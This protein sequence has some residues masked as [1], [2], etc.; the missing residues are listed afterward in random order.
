MG[1]AWHMWANAPG[2]DFFERNWLMLHAGSTWW[3]QIPPLVMGIAGIPAV[4]FLTR[5]FRFQAWICL[6]ST[7][8][9]TM[10]PVCIVFS[11]RYKEY[12]ADFLLACLLLALAERARRHPGRRE[13]F[14][15]SAV[16]VAGFAVSASVLPIVAGSW[17]AVGVLALKERQRLLPLLYPAILTGAGILVIGDVFYR[18]L[19]PYLDKYWSS[20][21][22]A[23]NSPQAFVSK[24][25]RLTVNVYAGLTGAPRGSQLWILVSFLLLTGLLVLGLARGWSMLSPL[26]MLGSAYVACALGV[27][28][29]GTGRADEVLYPALLLLLAGGLKKLSDLVVQ[30]SSCAAWSHL[31]VRVVVGIVI[32]FLVLVGVSTDSGY[33]SVDIRGLAGAVVRSTQPGDHVVVDSFLR[34]SWT[35]YEDP[36][37]HIIFGSDWVTGF[38]VASTQPAVFIVPS[39]SFEG[40]YESATW[41]RNLAHYKRIWLVE[42]PPFTQSPMYAALHSAGWRPG[43]IIH[44][45]DCEA[46]LLER[47]R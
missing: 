18:H 9:V 16:S 46:V 32:S 22:F 7:L 36:H 30:Q 40:G 8:V 20:D 25:S 6:A 27:I 24:A 1:T 10:S 17:L 14:L 19:S 13:L 31:S 45:T 39:F 26:L 34:Y 43:K 3:G 35:L 42:V 33:H 37:P 28:P 5:Y 29:L 11:T 23:Y 21:F 15:L 47:S 41:I 2:F 12:S 44:A 38:T 4:F